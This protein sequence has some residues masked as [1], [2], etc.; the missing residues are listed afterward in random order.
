LV[1]GWFKQLP[2]LPRCAAGPGD[3]L[4]RQLRIAFC[5]LDVR[6][7]EYLCEFVKIAAVHHVP[8]CKSVTQIMKPEV[9]NL[10]SVEQVFK[11]PLHALPPT[12]GL[13][14]R[15]KDKVTVRDEANIVLRRLGN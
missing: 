15:R 8:R 10:C 3:M 14:F 11:T 5:H 4:P 7:A 2:H 1:A 6:V 9:L 12:L 13:P